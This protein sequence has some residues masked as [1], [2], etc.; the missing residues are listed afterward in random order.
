MFD[1]LVS[2]EACGTGISDT[3][4]PEATTEGLKVRLTSLAL[5]DEGCELAGTRQ[6]FQLLGVGVGHCSLFERRSDRLRG[7]QCGAFLRRKGVIG[8]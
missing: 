8:I 6:F 4:G 2:P 5:Q 7:W 3:I 1:L